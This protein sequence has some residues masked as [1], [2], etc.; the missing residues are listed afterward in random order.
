MELGHGVFDDPD[1]I[2]GIV[3]GEISVVAQGLYLRAKDAG[4]G[5]VKG[6]G[7]HILATGAQHARQARA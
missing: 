3:D 7:V 4:A 5:R 6:G 1:G 2:I